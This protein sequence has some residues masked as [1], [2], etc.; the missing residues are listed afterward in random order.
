LLLQWPRLSTSGAHND[1]VTMLY[2]DAQSI[3][4][5]EVVKLCVAYVLSAYL[6]LG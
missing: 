2:N 1:N 4:R 3:E 5:R 6:T